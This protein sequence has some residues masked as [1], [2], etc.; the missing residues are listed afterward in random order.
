VKVIRREGGGG[1]G[2]GS[3]RKQCGLVHEVLKLDNG[4]L[5]KYMNVSHCIAEQ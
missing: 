4:A 1:G 5:N 3:L 2:V